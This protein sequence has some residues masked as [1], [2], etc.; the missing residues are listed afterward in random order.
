[1]KINTQTGQR[2]YSRAK[3]IIPGGTHLLSKRPE[4][5]LPEKWP[6]YFAKAK[7]AEVWDLDGNRFLDFSHFGVGACSLGYADDEVDAAVKEA[8]NS[9]V[10]STLNCPNEVELAEFLLERHT[11]ADMV[12]FARGG[13]EAMA[14]ASRIARAATGKDV[15][16]CCG[17]H[18]WADWYLAANLGTS[19]ALDGHL[20][21]GLNP[22]G[23]PRALGESIFT[24]TY[25][26]ADAFTR[27]MRSMADRVAAVIM[28]PQ[29]NDPPA[30]GFLELVRSECDQ[31][32]A[33]LCFDEITSGW[34]TNTGG[35]HLDF[36]VTPDLAVF[37]K[38]MGNGYAMSAVIGKTAVMEAAQKTFI[39][40]TAWTERIGPAAAL[41]T[42]RKHQRLDVGSHL[43]DVGRLIQA[44]WRKAAAN[45][46]LN[47]KVYGLPPLSGFAIESE[48]ADVL[49]TIFTQEML[50][51]GY[52]SAGQF[53]G[54]LAHSEE[55]IAAY[56]ENVGSVFEIMSGIDSI[57]AAKELLD[58]PAKHSG[59][60]RLN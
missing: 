15:I 20:L 12:R 59:F 22:A 44:G 16:L 43:S 55:S 58:G 35:L 39:S 30:P 21:P 2:L 47:I 60:A 54:T 23:V 24:F 32:R 27:L 42:L 36:G 45:V 48:H 7:G 49:M 3:Q 31:A 1:M 9:G 28:E 34:R 17:Y 46:N 19:E 26:E 53:Y 11:W 40:S 52:L 37:A 51:R 6:N 13:G 56:L 38:A 57:D 8:I 18:G 29:R 41:A 50:R 5:F 4:M 14:I 25:N 33:V 10:C